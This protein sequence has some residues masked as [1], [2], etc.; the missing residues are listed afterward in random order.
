MRRCC[1]SSRMPS[2]ALTESAARCSLMLCSYDDSPLLNDLEGAGGGAEGL[3]DTSTAFKVRKFLIAS[4]FLPCSCSSVT[5]PITNCS[6]EPTVGI[7][8]LNCVLLF[9]AMA[10]ACC[11]SNLASLT[12]WTVV[13]SLLAILARSNSCFFSMTFKRVIV[14]IV[15]VP[16]NPVINASE[17]KIKNFTR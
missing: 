1:N 5:W 9:S 3:G 2:S 7:I 14:S 10:T 15:L 6:V 13:S 4:S 16:T 17:R 8:F 11:A 12:K